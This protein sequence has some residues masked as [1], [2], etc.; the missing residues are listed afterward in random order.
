MQV[1]PETVTVPHSDCAAPAAV[2]A[3][4]SASSVTSLKKS[5]CSLSRVSTVELFK[6]C[7]FSV[8]WPN[9]A[10]RRRHEYTE[11]SKIV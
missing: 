2:A 11:A 8:L 4:S 9:D 7:S 6:A 1:Q 3:A 10:A 5:S